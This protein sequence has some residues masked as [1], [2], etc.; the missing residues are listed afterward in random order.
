[1]KSIKSID[2]EKKYLSPEIVEK[3]K[4]IKRELNIKSDKDLAKLIGI[5]NSLFSYILNRIKPLT[6][7]K[8]YKINKFLSNPS[9]T[10]LKQSNIAERDGEVIQI[11]AGEN[12]TIKL[13]VPKECKELFGLLQTLIETK[14]QR[15]E[16]LKKI[17]SM[18]EKGV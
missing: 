18:Y 16:D 10:S 7:E 12:N 1:M 11:N 17:I 14:N 15:I 8:E 5:D 2:K 9:K 6:P 4:E 13:R 3:L